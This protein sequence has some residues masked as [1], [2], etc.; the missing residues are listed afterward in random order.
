MATRTG[1][2]VKKARQL[3]AGGLLGKPHS[4]TMDWI[5][6]QTRL[7]SP[8][9]HKSW[10][11]FKD[12]AGG[13]KLIF[14]GVHYLDVI[15]FLVGDSIREVSCFCQNVGGQTIEVEDIAVVNF[16]FS[17]GMIGTLNTGY[18]LDQGKQLNI[19]VW[20]SHGWLRL[21]FRAKTP[22]EWYSTHPDAPRGVQQ[23]GDTTGGYQPFFQEAIDA[24]RG[25]TEW[26]IT[27]FGITTRAEG[28]LRRLPRCGIRSDAKDLIV[29]ST[30]PS[31]DSAACRVS[32]RRH[33]RS[34]TPRPTRHWCRRTIRRQR[35]CIAGQRRT[36]DRRRRQLV[37]RFYASSQGNSREGEWAGENRHN[38]ITKTEK[39]VAIL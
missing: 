19:R 38:S 21:D 39:Q 3:I 35:I 16:R 31:V 37:E 23:F 22:L 20:G 4:A 27:Q 9:Y 7:K 1:A 33:F 2:A 26:P 5:A 15:Q 34:W 28:R 17:G 25:K 10:L 30:R 29:R 11:S 14:H 18:Y 32:S 13:G 8:A 36:S 24:V 12:Q 6:D